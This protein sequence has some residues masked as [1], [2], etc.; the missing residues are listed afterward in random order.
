MINNV[1][2][3]SIV[4]IFLDKIF[5]NL[6]L[7]NVDV[8]SYELDHI[9]YRVSSIE[10]YIIIKKYLYDKSELLSENIVS[11]RKIATYKLF[12]PIKY[13]NREINLIEI[14]APKIWSN[15][16]DWFEHVEFVI[17]I[18]F[19]EFI[20][21]YQKLNYW[22]DSLNKKINPELKLLFWD[23]SVKFHHYNLE[24]VINNFE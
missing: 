23:C 1:F 7:S 13:K 10:N 2:G 16:E 22:L 20:N 11:W 4:N 19:E 18:S 3:Q 5:L 12:E 6:E 8:S 21:K 14:P 15:Y 24:Y 9:C 17:D